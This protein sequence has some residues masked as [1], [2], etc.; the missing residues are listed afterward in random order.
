MIKNSPLKHI[1]ITNFSKEG[2][3]RG[4]FYHSD[5]QKWVPIDVPFT[6]PGECVTA[7]LCGKKKKV[8]QGKLVE[9][10]SFS[11]SRV[12]A[13][14]SH[15]GSCGGCKWQHIDYTEQLRI[16]E[17]FVREK[18]RS[19]I[20][21]DTLC[22]PII[23]SDPYFRYRNKLELTFS[24]DK[25]GRRYLG[26]IIQGSR[27]HAFHMRECHL[28]HSW[29]AEVVS[30]VY[31]WWEKWNLAAYKS[32]TNSGTL[33]TLIIRE[34][35]RT[36]D[37]LVMLTVSCDPQFAFDRKTLDDFVSSCRRVCEKDLEEGKLSLFLRWQQIAVGKPTQFYEMLLYGSD[38]LRETLYI[39]TQHSQIEPFYFRVSPSAFF[40]PNTLQAEKLYSKAIQLTEVTREDIV[41]D[42]YCGTGT[43]GI[44]MA[45]SAK[46]VIGIEL[47]P[48]SALDAVENVKYNQLHNVSVHTGDVGKVL[49]QLLE[50]SEKPTAI[51]V[52]PPRAGL[53][54]KAI[55]EIAAI[56]P[57]KL[58]YISCNPATQAENCALWVNRGYRITAI[59]SVD[60]F[61]H[62]PHVENI[63]ALRLT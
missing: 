36:K 25:E 26:L 39:E 19:L 24:S 5:M 1:D 11:K 33:R 54:P 34:G 37:R 22:L 46:K 32:S 29:A 2:F 23:S 10:Q 49:P 63:V 51:I 61:P 31:E 18:F 45:K 48:E 16:K 38:H 40:Q 52:D 6:L 42:L 47:S 17:A 58:T 50:K 56:R 30:T 53:C 7:S 60:Q 57:Q 15:F 27:G 41:Y 55:E 20:N 8:R 62:T 14:C 35:I 12:S 43:L 28:M 59:Q 21:Q 9:L 3:G 44:C 13:P 4:F